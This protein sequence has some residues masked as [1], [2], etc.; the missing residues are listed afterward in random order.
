MPR[1]EL[2]PTVRY[3]G[4]DPYHVQYD[5]LPI[6]SILERQAIMN[7]AIDLSADI[8]RD[9]VGDA[10]TLSARLGQALDPNGD[11]LSSAMDNPVD[12]AGSTLYHNI[13]AHTDG[14]FDD[15]SGDKVYVR[16][17]EDERDKLELVDDE[18]TNLTI[19]FETVS[20]ILAFPPAEN[21]VRF[22]PS[23]S[24]TVEVDT[25]NTIQFNTVFPVSAAHD[26]FYDQ[27][28]VHVTPSSPNYINYKVNTLSTAY[29]E[30]SLRIYVNGIRL[31]E[32]DSVY[33][34]G[35][36]GPSA[37]WA[38]LSYTP[39]ETAGTFQL[40]RAIDPDDIIRIDYDR[41]YS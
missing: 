38:L 30:G 17:L 28:P 20:T 15:G 36:S 5:N 6:D 18:A 29:V 40:S 32:T 27:E 3:S 33:V 10:G 21:T 31:T 8:I 19:Q 35:P 22:S 9:S 11:L 16:M 1:I 2:I 7:A 4:S 34:P 25:P 12:G 39:N 23:S 13:G 14:S 37:S 26:H 24:I 41:A